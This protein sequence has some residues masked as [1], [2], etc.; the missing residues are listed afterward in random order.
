MMSY[1]GQIVS[2]GELKS[3][4]TKTGKDWM[5]QQYV[6]L[7]RSNPNYEKHIAFEVFGK[8]KLNLFNLKEG[9]FVTVELDVESRIWNERWF[10]NVRCIKCEKE[11]QAAP[12]PEPEPAPAPK[13]KKET[14][15]EKLKKQMAELQAKLDKVPEPEPV[16]ES[17]NDQLPF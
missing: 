10:T 5:T 9:D 13:N 2:V 12:E 6:L 4:T 16:D 17:K 11:G 1:S 14:E 15:R 3:G 7:D 8:E